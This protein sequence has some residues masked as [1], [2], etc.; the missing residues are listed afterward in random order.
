M[1]GPYTDHHV[2]I[3]STVAARLSVD[4]SA[5]GSLD[6]MGRA[7]RR[8][9][10]LGGAWIRA[11]GYEEWALAERRHPTREDLDRFAPGRPLVLHHRSGHAAVL[12]SAALAEVGDPG[13]PDGVLFDRHDLL[14][15]VPRLD[16]AALREAA[17]AVSRE[18]EAAGVRAVTDATHTN[19]LSDLETLATWCAQGVVRQEVTAMVAPEAA[20]SVPPFGGTVG[21]VTVGPVKLMPAPA[22]LG[23]LA[24]AVAAAH[25][26]GFP[27]AV[28]VVDVDVLDSTLDAFERSGPPPGTGDRIEHNALCLPE[29]V[30]RIAACGAAVV[31]NPSFLAHRRRKYS[32]QIPPVEQEWL[33][34][35][36]SLLRAGIRVRAGSDSPVTPSIPDEMIAA[37]MSHPFVPHESVT[38]EQAEA[39]LSP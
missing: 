7:I 23:G 39:L 28:H 6:E 29:Q 22:V 8:A 16:P 32:Q 26:A 12:N 21:P 34:R 13:H 15:L 14:S 33:I 37:A 3:L 35:I 27:V 24:A 1:P 9:A 10:P 19:G 18:W 38:R 20:A 5:A 2:H 31:V 25:R 36:G 17:T 4:V 30:P 11:W